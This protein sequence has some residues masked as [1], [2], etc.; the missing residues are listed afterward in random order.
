MIYGII[1]RPSKFDA[2]KTYPVIEQIYGGPQNFF[3]PKAFST[4]VKEYELADLGFVSS[5]QRYGH[6]LAIESILRSLL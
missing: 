3:V 1:I 6:E 5:S 2:G 4:S